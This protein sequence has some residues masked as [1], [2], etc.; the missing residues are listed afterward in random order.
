MGGLAV[1]ELLSKERVGKMVIK[2]QMRLGMTGSFW[3][4]RLGMET[5]MGPLLRAL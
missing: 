1:K 5:M 3:M 4:L 2:N